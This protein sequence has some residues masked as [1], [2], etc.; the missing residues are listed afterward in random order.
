MTLKDQSTIYLTKKLFLLMER[1]RRYQFLILLTLMILTSMF[2][3]ISIGAVIPFLGVLIEPSNIFE[4]PA[5]QPFIQFLGVDQPTQI[6]FPISALFAIAVLMSG[7]MRVLLLWASVKFSF[8]LGVDLSVGIFTQVINQPYIAHTKQNSSD[9]ISAISIKIAQVINGVVLS[10]LNIIS[11]F[12]IVTAIITILIII[13]PS[14]SLIAILFFS[15]LYVFFYLYVKQ[16]LKVNSLNITHA[17]NSLMKILQEALGGIRDIIINGN[18]QFYRS[19][20]WR[21]DLIFRKSLGNTLFLTN[22]PRY[23]METFG[24]LLIVLLAYMLS[25]QGE[26]SF[27]DGIPVLGALALG[28]QRLLPVMQV[29]YNSWGNVKGT[30]FVLAEVLGFLSLNDSKTMNVI[31]DDCSFEKNIRLKDVSFGYDENSLP[32]INKINI[33]IKKGDCIGVI[34]KTGSGKSTLIDIMMGL[35]DPTDGTLEVDENVIT[36]SNR[37]AWQSRI[38]HV[39]QN[40]Y[41]SD[42]TLEENIAFGIPVEEIDSSLVRRAAI[43]ANIDSVVNEWPLKY[44]TILGERGIRLSGGQR[45]RI[46]IARA[47]YKQADVLFLDEATSS[48]DSTTE[49][50]IMKAIEKLGN[51]VTL[52]I[53]AHRIT[54]LKNCSRI[55]ELTNEGKID[56]KV[57]SDI[58]ESSLE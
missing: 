25:T 23:F 47:L 13:N 15:A 37:R 46:G 17:S 40:I 56:E 29:L 30:H 3:V 20:F 35:L 24:I 27:A 11:S 43:S 4:L 8:I 53:I 10:V 1:R 7:A 9:I 22:S 6:I 51:D 54:T 57:Y 34:G 21:A 42:S 50:S 16:K 45:Q 48:V 18:Q 14:A 19:I 31:N 58:T 5:A 12:I 2:E 26:K 39:P 36:S 33:D 28:A 52:I 49:S 44:K 41:L 55:L 38:A 32:T